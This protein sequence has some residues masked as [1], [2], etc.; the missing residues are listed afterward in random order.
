MEPNATPAR[1]TYEELLRHLWRYLRGSMSPHNWALDG[2]ALISLAPLLGVGLLVGA[3]AL[4][5]G[6]LLSLPWH[7][8]VWTARDLSK[9][10]DPVPLHHE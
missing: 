6:Y 3:A 8:A 5:L 10:V 9:P 4:V 2:L 7:I 1:P